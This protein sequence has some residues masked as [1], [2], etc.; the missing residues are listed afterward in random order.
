MSKQ[1]GQGRIEQPNK[2]QEQNKDLKKGVSHEPMK[3]Q[4]QQQQQQQPKKQGAP[5]SPGRQGNGNG[6]N[7]K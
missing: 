3:E 4:Q 1:N 5:G 6:R 2:R 7:K